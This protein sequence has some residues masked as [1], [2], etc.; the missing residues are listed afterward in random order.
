[1]MTIKK[2]TVITLC[3]YCAVELAIIAAMVLSGSCHA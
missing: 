3:V 2:S 1:M